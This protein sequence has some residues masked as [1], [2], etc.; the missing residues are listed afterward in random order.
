MQL[1]IN[2]IAWVRINLNQGDS[3]MINRYVL[4][5]TCILLLVTA[6]FSIK[7]VVDNK[8]NK[9]REAGYTA[10]MSDILSSIVKNGFVNINFTDKSGQVQSVRLIEGKAK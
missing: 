7:P 8:I 5:L 9:L 10:A 2:A 3:M 6:F 4:T 1:L